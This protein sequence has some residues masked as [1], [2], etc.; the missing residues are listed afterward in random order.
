[1]NVNMIKILDNVRAT[2][3]KFSNIPRV[4]ICLLFVWRSKTIPKTISIKT[5]KDRLN[6]FNVDYCADIISLQNETKIWM[7]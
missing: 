1:M 4:W 7:I 2:T 3:N 5:P 6:I